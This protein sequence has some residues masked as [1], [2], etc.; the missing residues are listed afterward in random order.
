MDE[1]ITNPD[2]S[3]NYQNYLYKLPQETKRIMEQED[4]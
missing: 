4:N 2:G 1:I 3:F